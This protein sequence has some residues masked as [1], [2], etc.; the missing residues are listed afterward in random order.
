MRIF[1]INVYLNE[2]RVHKL[3][4][5]FYPDDFRKLPIKTLKDQTFF[6]DFVNILHFLY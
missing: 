2:I 4:N 3:P 1:E 6:V 5:T